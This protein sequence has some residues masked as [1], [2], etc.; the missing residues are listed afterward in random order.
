MTRLR[1]VCGHPDWR[2]EP[3]PAIANRNECWAWLADVGRWCQCRQYQEARAAAE[4]QRGE[5]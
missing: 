2:H 4:A 3:N 5:S 1:C